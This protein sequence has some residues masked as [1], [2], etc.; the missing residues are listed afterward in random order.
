MRVNGRLSGGWYDRLICDDRGFTSVG[1]AVSLLLTVSLLLSS[2]QVYKINSASAEIQDVADAAAL[3]AQNEVAEFVT[4]V[5][6]CDA[7]V[8]SMSLLG[9]ATYG[10][11]IVTMCAPATE[12]L[13]L[14]LFEFGKKV[15]EAR[16]DFAQKAAS[17]LNEVQS[18]LPFIAAV[19]AAQVAAAND[20]SG[21]L[22]ARYQAVA[23]LVPFEGSKISVPAF[24]ENGQLEQSV[25]EQAEDIRNAAAEMEDLSLQAQEIKRRAFEADCGASPDRCM[26]ERASRLAGLDAASNPLYQS[27][28]TWS[29]SVA[30]DRARAYYA[31]R[32][33]SERPSGSTKEQAN[34]ALRSL[35][36]SYALEQ[37]A[38]AYVHETEDS[39]S[40]H[41]PTLPAN[42]A[43][44]RSSALYDRA[45]FP[46]TVSGGVSVAHAWDGCPGARGVE[47]YASARQVE[48]GEFARCTQCEFDVSSFGNVAA[49]TSS[50]SSGFEFHYRQVAQAAESYERLRAELDPLAQET[51]RRLDGLLE[52][53]SDLA[54]NLKDVRLEAS[55][56]GGIGAV[57]MVVN[58]ASSDAGFSSSLAGEARLG[59]RFAVAGATLLEEPA[60]P[61]GSV[62]ASLLDGFV[63][64]D[65]SA[66]GAARVVLDGWSALLEAYGSGQEALTSTVETVLEA[67]PIVG[68]SGLSDWAAKRFKE[69]MGSVGLQPVDLDSAKAVLVNT[70]RISSSGADA[71]AVRYGS[72]QSAALSASS[73]ATDPLSALTS[74]LE[75]G[76]FSWIDSA[77]SNGFEIARIELP[78]GNVSVPV[79]IELP[80]STGD[81]ARDVVEASLDS[82]K[83][84]CASR[85]EVSSWE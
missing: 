1:M 83:S 51:K 31:A 48:E 29:F 36:Y 22:P 26:Q 2:A 23:V 45:E 80:C 60:S 64:E 5:R 9:L 12:Q 46:Y 37:L 33:S 50:I 66:I 84:V 77:E 41:F 28:D 40:A 8:L 39:F 82:L 56:P 67:I 6:V 27:I 65:G 68:G 81:W 34:S 38:S 32:L 11:G 53:C 73:P 25:D 62:V 71:F 30:L 61:D 49:A 14:K 75:S 59:A 69:L 16:D 17:G 20:D 42:A 3:A 52:Q 24:G 58:L 63:G 21:A 13:S 74:G 4:M 35:Y 10:A 76:V 85:L 43:E 70:A 44:M 18:A 47:G 54:R 15:F 79:V 78:V 55:P 72:L 57:A 7:L 19:S